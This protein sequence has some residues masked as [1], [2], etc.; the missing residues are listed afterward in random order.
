LKSPCPR[1]ASVR[2][3]SNRML[4]RGRCDLVERGAAGDLWSAAVEPRTEARGRRQQVA[5]PGRRG[6]GGMER[7]VEVGWGLTGT[8]CWSGAACV[9]EQ[10]GWSGA[11]GWSVAPDGYIQKLGP[12]RIPFPFFSLSK[13]PPIFSFFAATPST[14][15]KSPRL[16]GTAQWRAYLDPHGASRNPEEHA[17]E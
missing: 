10:Q 16:S 2:S 9:E 3:A 8:N 1:R 12:V 17:T 15:G 5:L 14:H 7:G 11:G 6:R 13:F 4:E